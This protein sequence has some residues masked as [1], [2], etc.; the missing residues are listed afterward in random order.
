MV[1][2]PQKNLPTRLQI[3]SSLYLAKGPS[4]NTEVIFVD[5][6]AKGKPEIISHWLLQGSLLDSRRS[7][8]DRIQLAFQDRI[9]LPNSIQNDLKLQKKLNKY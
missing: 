7:L 1:L 4:A 9:Q 2:L 6:S 5:I 3:R 8:N